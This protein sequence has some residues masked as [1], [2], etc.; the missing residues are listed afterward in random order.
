MFGKHFHTNKKERFGLRKFKQG[1]ASVT[2]GAL[3]FTTAVQVGGFPSSD[4]QVVYAAEATYLTS[5][6]WTLN[7]QISS[8]N[9]YIDPNFMTAYTGAETIIRNEEGKEIKLTATITPFGTVPEGVSYLVEG[10]NQSSYGATS[11]MFVGNP[12][13]AT[14]PALGI[15]V[16]PI[17]YNNPSQWDFNGAREEAVITFRFSEPVVNPIID[18]SGIGGSADGYLDRETNGRGSYNSTILSLLTNGVR[19]EAASTGANLKVT[20]TVIEA[21]EKNTYNRSVVPADASGTGSGR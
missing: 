20:D 16:Q 1:L 21:A 4:S 6:N 18:V 12:N 11:D 8:G 5:T 19:L 7:N 3:L 13:P 17:P 10:D 9:K 14:T 2:V 15:Y